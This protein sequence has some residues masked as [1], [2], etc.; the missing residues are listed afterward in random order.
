M[1]EVKQRSVLWKLKN[2]FSGFSLNILVLLLV[3]L[4]L[5]SGCVSEKDRPEIVEQKIEES[6]PESDLTENTTVGKEVKAQIENIESTK[7]AL[8]SLPCS[9]FEC[10]MY[11]SQNSQICL[12]YC[13]SSPSDSTCQS[14]KSMLDSFGGGG[15]ET[16]SGSPEIQK[17]IK[18]DFIELDKIQRISK[19]RSGYGHDYSTPSS[20]TCRSMKHYYWAKGGMPGGSHTPAWTSIKYFAPVDGKISFLRTGTDSNGETEYYFTIIPNEHP[21]YKL[22]FFHVNLLPA[23]RKGGS[24]TEGQHIGHLSDEYVHGEIAVQA[25]NS[26]VSFFEIITDEL[27]EEYKQKGAQSR[28]DF[29]IAKEERNEKLLKCDPNTEEGRFFGG[30]ID[31]LKDSTGLASWFELK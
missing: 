21:S 9:D 10:Y 6:L 12:D 11:C 16:S 14:M 26:L 8:T 1:E 24:V 19:Y 20:E 4:V 3:S 2:K 29:V 13:Q 17:F 18:H 22:N 28:D 30:S 31:G 15:V 5:M 25:G 27:F 7:K 23:F